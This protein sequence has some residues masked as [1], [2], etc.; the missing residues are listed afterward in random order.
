[1]S[2]QA[3]LDWLTALPPGVL[4]GAMFLLA[5]TENI[6]PPIP[7]DLLIALGAFLAARADTS[8]WPSFLAVLAGNV[9]GAMGMYALG[10]RFG[11]AWTERRLHVR[12]AADANTTLVR[13]YAEFGTTALF[14]GRFVPGVRAVVAPVAG[15]LHTPAIRTAVAITGASG[16][17]YGMVMLVAYHAGSNWEG[18]LATLARLGRN[19]AVV[20]IVLLGVV[21]LLWWRHRRRRHSPP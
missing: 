13:S 2:P 12:A 19:T 9:G 14:L 17:W 4:L 18:L 20:A 1:V 10:R 7:A 8:P 16:I 6:F 21:A 5:A 3:V 15:A 11:A